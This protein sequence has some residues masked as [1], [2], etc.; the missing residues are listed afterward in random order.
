[1]RLG[2]FYLCSLAVLLAAAAEAQQD[3]AA[4]VGQWQGS[5]TA[6]TAKEPG[7]ARSRELGAGRSTTKLPVLVTIIAGA[8]GKLSGSWTG[9]TQQGTQP[10]E[11][12][13]EGDVIRLLLPATM[14]SW[15]GKLSADGSKLEGRWEGKTFGGDASA[16]L[17]LRR[18]DK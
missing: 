9:T 8:D 17:V 10:I 13:M 15:E 1:M 14:S 7:A 2:R 4:L 12:A 11:I 16:P 6:R 18:S 3:A 5:Y